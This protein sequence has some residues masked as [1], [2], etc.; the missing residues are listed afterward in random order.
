MRGDDEIKEQPHTMPAVKQKIFRRITMKKILCI[1]IV[2][3]A[4]FVLVACADEAPT[5]TPAPAADA[6][7]APDAP[8]GDPP[9]TADQVTTITMSVWDTIPADVSWI[10]EFQAANPDIRVELVDLDAGEYSAIVNTMVLG[11]TATDVI[12]AW[13]VDLPRFARMG[14]ISP[15]DDLV[16]NSTLIDANDLMPAVGALAEM[17]DGL[18]GL[19]WVYASHFLFFNKDM[20]DAAGI[21]YPTDDWTWQDMEDAAVALTIREGGV[22]TQWGMTDIDFGGIWYSMIGQAGDDVIDSNL[23]LAMGSGLR[24]TLEFMYRLTN[25]LEVV[26]QPGGAG[27]VDLFAA[28]MAAMRRHG[29][30]NVPGYS[31]V[32]FRWDIVPLPGDV[33]DHSALHTGMFTINAASPHQDE[34]WRFIEFLMSHQGQRL[35]SEFSANVSSVMS[36]AAEGHHFVQGVNGPSNW[37]AFDAFG[38]YG[39]FTFTLLNPAVTGDLVGQFNAVLLGLTTIDDVVNNQV[40]AAQT[41]LDALD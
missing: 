32:P 7:P 16:A 9:A 23:N 25:E 18:Y 12:L 41:R 27:D 29:N 36:V 11:G 15:M 20:F 5:A 35:L 2:I 13:E 10:V 26:P 3:C 22:T 21:P 17:T 24:R 1:L 19:P 40:A 28:E 38:N 4:A 6:T 14:V 39:R 31:D 37:G 34:A 33:R 8:P 30:W